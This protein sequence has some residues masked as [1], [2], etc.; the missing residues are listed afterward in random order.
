MGQ[1]MKREIR[2]K[3][4][5]LISLATA[6]VTF[7]L[8]PTNCIATERLFTEIAVDLPPA[9]DGDERAAFIT[10][11]R[12][13]YMVSLGKKD[14]KGESYLAQVSVYI[15]P[16]TQNF[17]AKES[18]LKLAASQ[19]DTSTPVQ[20][21]VFWKFSG[22]TKSNIIKGLT[23]TRVA[24]SPKWWCIIMTQDPL[25]KEAEQIVA[26]LRGISERAGILLG[27]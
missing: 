3:I 21:G 11:N 15:L 2:M 13:E 5:F 20:D 4:A 8:F 9:W 6:C 24:A 25:G 22:Y 27:K 19:D 12:D 7:L 16:N 18:A 26:S 17:S 14:D 1:F 23:I 10:G